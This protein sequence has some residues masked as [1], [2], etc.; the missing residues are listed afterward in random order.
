[1]LTRRDGMT[2]NLMSVARSVGVLGALLCGG[3]GLV[4]GGCAA[5]EPVGH[6]KETTKTV[7]ETPEGTQTTTET[8]EKDT[9]VYPK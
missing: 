4:T 1:M 5:D 6:K 7:V 8:H 9:K 2:V 3:F